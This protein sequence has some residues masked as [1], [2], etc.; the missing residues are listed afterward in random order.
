M[1]E[2]EQM[3][4]TQALN[5]FDQLIAHGRGT[6]GD[7]E[8]ALDEVLVL[9]PAQVEALAQRRA[10]G[11]REARMILI[12]RDRLIVLRGVEQLMKEIFDVGGI[13]LRRRVGLGYAD[14]LQEAQPVGI[15]IAAALRDRL[16]E[17]IAEA[18][19]VPGAVI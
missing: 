11:A 14:Q 6:A 5:F 12:A 15:G 3:T 17:I 8:A 9:E 1:Q 19:R 16:P 2:R 4:D 18:V 7:E 13:F 10:H